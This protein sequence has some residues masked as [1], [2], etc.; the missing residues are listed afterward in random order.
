[1]A[2]DEAVVVDS[3]GAASLLSSC[4][5]TSKDGEGS[6]KGGG[7]TKD[8]SPPGKSESTGADCCAA[9]AAIL[10]VELSAR[11][12]PQCRRSPNAKMFLDWKAW[13]PLTGAAPPTVPTCRLCREANPSGV[14]DRVKRARSTIVHPIVADSGTWTSRMDGSGMDVK[15]NDQLCICMWGEMKEAANF[16]DLADLMAR[17]MDEYAATGSVASGER[18]PFAAQMCSPG[19]LPTIKQDKLIKLRE[20]F[21]GWT[22]DTIYNMIS[23]KPDALDD[24]Q[25][26]EL[27]KALEP[28]GFTPVRS[29]PV[30]G[31]V[32]SPFIVILCGGIASFG[33]SE[34]IPHLPSPLPH[35]STPSIHSLTYLSTLLG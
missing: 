33:L 3:A 21:F 7:E 20:L 19:W 16:C 30:V 34:Y 12:C 13:S 4:T 29:R 15:F 1:M 11:Q 2:D 14:D 18:I 25:H 5:I 24:L 32:Q 23:S 8:H 31:I 6:G 28:L 10:S 17:N 9:E 35:P 22:R 26:V 27:K